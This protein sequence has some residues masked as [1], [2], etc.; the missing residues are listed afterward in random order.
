MSSG[1]TC[2]V[3]GCANDAARNSLCWGHLKRRTREQRLSDLRE[4]VDGKGPKARW[5]RIAKAAIEFADDTERPVKHG[6]NPRVA[7]ERAKGK[8]RSALKR[9]VA[10]LLPA[11]YRFEVGKG[12]RVRFWRR[13]LPKPK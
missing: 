3:E 8:F 7:E 9:Y 2:S 1:I 11:V 5:S 12:G 6:E 4:R 13:D 10:E